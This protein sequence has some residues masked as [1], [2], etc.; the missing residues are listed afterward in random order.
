ME[1]K[2]RFYVIRCWSDDEEFYKVGITTKS[3]KHRFSGK[4]FPYQYEIKQ[5][6]I[7]DAENIWNLEKV[8]KRLA[9]DL[10]YTPKQYFQGITECFKL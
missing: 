8:V 10:Q 3:I 6:I 7:D 9:K 5:E 4:Y 1:G 2:A